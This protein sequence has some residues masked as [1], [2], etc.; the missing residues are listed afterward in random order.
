MSSFKFLF[1]TANKQSVNYFGL[2]MKDANLCLSNGGKDAMPI[3]LYFSNRLEELAEKFS[4]IVARENQE[5]ESVLEESLA[6]V[7]NQNLIKWLQLTVAKRQSVLMNVD[8]QYLDAGL[9]NLIARLDGREEKPVMMDHAFRQ[10]LL[11]YGLQTLSPSE[12]SYEPLTRYLLGPDGQRGPDYGVKLWQLTEKMIHLFEEYEFHRSHMIR[13]WTDGSAR[14]VGMELCQQKLYLRLRDIRDGYAGKTGRRVLS[15]GE[16]A[17]EILTPSRSL[18]NDSDRRKF[19]HIFGLSQVSVFH[20]NVMGRLQQDYDIFIYALNPS[21]EFWEDIK[22]PRE[23]RWIERKNVRKLEITTDEREQGVLL[24][25]EDNDLLGLWGKP[26]RENI[27]LLCELTDYDFHS[28]FTKERSP[29]SVLQKL[30][31]NILTLST[32]NE[33]GDKRM[34]DRSLQIFACPGIYRE[35]ETVY[36]S[37]LYNLKIDETV[38]LTDIAIL[39]SDITRYKP[40]IDSFFNSGSG[41]LSYNLVDSRADTDS[42][43]AK[44]ILLLLAL[45]SGRFSRK[46]V[47]D[48][49][50]NPCFM[51]KWRIDGAEIEIWADWVD[52]LNIFHSFDAKA[53]KKRGYPESMYHTWEQGLQRLRLSRILSASNGGGGERSRHF[54]ELVPFSDIHTGDVKL[55]EKFS[56]IMEKL[57]RA[58]TELAAL[59]GSGERWNA[60]FLRICDDLL[61]IPPDFRGETA[62]QHALTKSFLDLK[63]YDQLQEGSSRKGPAQLNFEI[64]REFIKSS[65]SSIS[66]GRGDY[67][68]EGVTISALQPMRPIPFKIVYVLGM[69][70][71]SFP[72]NAD[73]SS[74]DLRLLKRRI[75]D[76][77]V[78]EKNCYL[79]LE[80]L[81]SVS[82]KLYI[83]YLSRDLQKDR[84]IQPCSVVNQLQTVVEREILDDNSRFGIV[85]I[86]LK[87]SSEKYLAENAVHDFS[88]VLVTYSLADRI[89]C[90]RELGLWEEVCREISKEEKT[91]LKSFFPDLG[92]KAQRPEKDQRI[93]EKISL[94][95]LKNFLEDPVSRGMRRH[96]GIYDEEETIEDIALR[97]DEPFYSVFPV[98]YNIKMESLNQW[99]NL[100]LSHENS[101]PP[102]WETLK[103]IS[104]QVYK[105]F[106]RNSVTPEG[107]YAELDQ[108]A[109]SEE[110]LARG[111]ILIPVF[112][113]MRAG[114]EIYRA[115]L[116]GEQADEKLSSDNRLPIVR[117]KAAKLSVETTDRLGE[118]METGVELHGQLP[119]VWKEKEGIWHALVVTGSGKTPNAKEPGRYILEPLLFWMTCLTT[120]DGRRYVS[121]PTMGDTTI[122]FHVAY[123]DCISKRTYHLNADDAEAY[124]KGLVS[125]TLDQERLEWLPFEKATSRSIKPHSASI[126]E[127]NENDEALFREQLVEA[128]REEEQFLIQLS[129]P[130]IP[131][132]AYKKVRDRFRIFFLFA[133]RQVNS[134]Q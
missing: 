103:N 111:E 9:W 82:D 50:V 69:E 7:P 102:R 17:T 42:V 65:L 106:Q 123:K 6:I 27:R 73:A 30:Q 83:S 85:H 74:L 124:L 88:D 76:V 55:M 21:R 117:F 94:K 58:A 53:K 121:D 57:Y 99:M 11:L 63:I 49:I 110:V 18:P 1:K 122:T 105:S 127:P 43:Y 25:P 29:E 133:G 26:G 34:Q 8:F 86:P 68:T 24:E 95:D 96:L 116:I 98:D 131:P 40:V 89:T 32:E 115:F 36:N 14:P 15:L 28:C 16:Y 60:V 129:N 66:G 44:G 52:N 128:Y 72:G 41:G 10:M 112:E 35:V 108:E 64:M 87:G 91:R 20:L 3:T 130:H 109:L 48:L 13:N 67:L 118:R 22:T 126:Y 61:E 38:Q 75:G 77:S 78:P 113:E 47:F 71:G 107:A 59:T 80:M 104:G 120:G 12:K 81:L 114:K 39:V 62:V 51:K 45:A 125:E 93:V 4:A 70:E 84:S 2:V 100:Q 37:I 79:F 90:Y 19:V 31:Q 56:M 46:E 101:E 119:W 97:E 33:G 134:E 92:I 5:K 54:H 132:D 23:R